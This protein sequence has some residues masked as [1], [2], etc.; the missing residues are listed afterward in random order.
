MKICGRTDGHTDVTTLIV[1]FHNSPNAPKKK[2]KQSVQCAVRAVILIKIQVK[3]RLNSVT[4]RVSLAVLYW[5][6]S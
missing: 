6:I 5:L 2:E 4:L 3:L 1:A